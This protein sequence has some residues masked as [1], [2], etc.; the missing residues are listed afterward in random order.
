MPTE[1]VENA[2][3]VANDAPRLPS[4]EEVVLT[5]GGHVMTKMTILKQVGSDIN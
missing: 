5:R 3:D 4:P 1:A 2:V